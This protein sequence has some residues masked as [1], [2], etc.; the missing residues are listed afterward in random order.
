LEKI[1]NLT[2]IIFS[3]TLLAT[4][5][6]SCSKNPAQEKKMEIL[7]TS[8][9]LSQWIHPDVPE[10]PNRPKDLVFLNPGESWKLI[11]DVQ[12]SNAT[13]KEVK[14]NT[15]NPKM[16]TI[17]NGIVTAHEHGKAVITATTV[18]GLTASIKI[19]SYPVTY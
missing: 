13:N 8:I 15:N 6:N 7:P 4:I 12:P 9:T 2:Q 1:L 11:A 14:W 10:Y 3:T 17:K 16:A 19:I 5:I 18:N